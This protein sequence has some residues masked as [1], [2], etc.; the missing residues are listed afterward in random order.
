MHDVNDDFYDYV[1]EA[2]AEP[3]SN[4]WSPGGGLLDG[5]RDLWQW[6]GLAAEIGQ[7]SQARIAFVGL[8]GAG[9]SLLFNRLRGWVISGQDAPAVS[10]SFELDADL[11][12]ESLGVFTL[13]DLPPQLPQNGWSGT[14]LLLSL[15]DPALVVYLLDSE[16]GVTAADYRWVALLR[17]TGR[18]L[19][20]L[21]NKCDLIADVAAVVSEASQKLGMPLIPISAQTG[22]N[23]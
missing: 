15:G 3:P 16:T 10:D 23:V 13:A 20:A 14:E 21:L 8:S 22:E 2:E 5:V 4:R 1:P 11:R 19:L 17:A 7:E 9:K 12:L 18:P 6:D